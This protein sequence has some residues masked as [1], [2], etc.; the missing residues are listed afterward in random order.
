MT[1]PT[2]RLKRCCLKVR[3]AGWLALVPL[4]LALVAGPLP[5][6]D[7][8]IRDDFVADPD[9]FDGDPLLW[10]INGP[11][12]HACCPAQ[13]VEQPGEGFCFTP[14]DTPATI[15][16][17][18]VTA[19]AF[20]S[21]VTLSA[22]VGV[23]AGVSLAVHWDPVTV[24]GYVFFLFTDRSGV[25]ARYDGNPNSPASQATGTVDFDPAVD[26]VR[27]ELRTVGPAVELRTWSVLSDRS[28][29]LLL[30]FDFDTTYR[31]GTVGF[32]AGPGGTACIR[33]AEITVTPPPPP[34]DTHC[35]GIEI[36]AIQEAG[37][38]V[39]VTAQA[40]DEGG[41][42]ISYVFSARLGFSTVQTRGPQ[43]EPTADFDLPPGEY[44][45]IVSVSDGSRCSPRAMDA[46]CSAK[47]VVPEAPPAG[48]QT[49]GDC[50]QD[51]S[52]D[53]S[54]AVCVLGFLFLGNPGRLPC[55]DGSSLDAANI[56]LIDWQSD[57]KIDLSDGIGLLL[58]L[59]SSGAPHPLGNQ[60][61]RVSGCPVACAL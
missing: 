27:L 8:V 45:I 37:A 54:D 57:A 17:Q 9:P 43:S 5:A 42:P 15:W 46:S 4:V 53:I 19:E 3:G 48:L 21:D 26:D 47:Y 51:R 13:V 35:Q 49:P 61:T 24:S 10:A 1:E 58:F 29:A 22:Q 32:G 33:W 11:N 44:T 40:N 18:F 59:F 50:N 7:Q 25:L 39:R 31:E 60:C 34:C 41:D 30:R 55:G 2:Q 20:N 12:W 23:G 36:S 6:V 14:I 56:S 38:N 28:E 16:S 52:L